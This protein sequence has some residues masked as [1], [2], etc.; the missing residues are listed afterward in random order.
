MVAEG[1]IVAWILPMRCFLFLL[2]SYIQVYVITMQS[3]PYLDKREV[4]QK[5]YSQ[6]PILPSPHFRWVVNR[7]TNIYLVCTFLTNRRRHYFALGI[8]TCWYLKRLKVAKNKNCVTS[9]AK[10]QRKPMEYR[11]RWVPDAKF[12]RW[13]CTFHVFYVNFMCWAPNANLFFSGIWALEL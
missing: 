4:L 5:E 11:L 8:P 10:P 7:K 12:S 2:L 13:A 6:P 3:F 1:C 9:N